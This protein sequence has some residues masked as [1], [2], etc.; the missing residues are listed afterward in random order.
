MTTMAQRGLTLAQSVLRDFSKNNGSYMAAGIAYWTLF[1]LFPLALAGISFLG[2]FY[3]TPQK[4]EEIIERIIVL[5]PVSGDY[6][7]DLI[8]SL[9]RARG[10]LGLLAIIGL[11]FSGAKVFAAIRR[12]INHVW[13][14][15]TPHS[16]ML[17][18]A[19]DFLMLLGVMLLVAVVLIFGAMI[20]GFLSLVGPASGVAGVALQIFQEILVWGFTFGVFILLYRYIPSTEVAWR[21]IWLGALVATLLFHVVRIGFTWFII[22]AEGFNIVYGSLGA[23]FAVLSWAYFSSLAL[24]WGAQVVATYSRL[25]GS[26]ASAVRREMP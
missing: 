22:H 2:F 12:G 5:V 10:A 19:I 15:N 25:Y 8:N 16:F 3:P 17:A 18:R 11:L 23:L 6:L 24:M 14:T 1:S 21:D 9:A 20:S 26:G 13:D 7:A 4:Q